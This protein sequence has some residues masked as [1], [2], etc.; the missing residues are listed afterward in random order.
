MVLAVF[1]TLLQLLILI[2]IGFWLSRARGY[3]RAL[4]QGLSRI[5]G[6]V[7]LPLYFFVTLAKTN[8]ADLRAGWVFPIIAAAVILLGL[9]IS[10]TLFRL[11]PMNDAER[12]AGMAMCSFGNASYIPL[13]LMEIFPVTLP[14]IASTFS[15]KTVS[16]YIGTYLLVNSPL[17]W[18]LGNYLLTGAGRRPKLNE[19]ITPPFVGILAGLAVVAFGVQGTLQDIRL[20]F[21]HVMVSLEKV[22]NLTVP[23][24]MI[25]L[26]A[27]IGEITITRETGR[28]LAAMALGVS[29]VRFFCLPLLFILGFLFVLRPL[30]LTP[31]QIWVVF[32]EMHVPPATNFTIMATRAGKNENH[33]SFTLLTTYLVYMFVLPVYL[34][35]FLSLMRL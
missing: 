7:A 26:G 25:S 11:L 35:V 5:T 2:A 19:L 14:V 34:L 30:G 24:I 13:G 32:L 31:V 18:T 28:G 23:L 21:F 16:L 20:P 10:A 6:N 15:Q 3:P 9:M 27:M 12:R 33:V 8:T 22:G 4:M 17:Q 1:Y 29:A